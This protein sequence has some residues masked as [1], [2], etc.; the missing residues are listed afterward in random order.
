MLSLRSVLKSE[1]D[2]SID[3][4]CVMPVAISALGNDSSQV[5][6]WERYDLLED[7]FGISSKVY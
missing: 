2:L 7:S 6:T 5:I 3:R 4:E 1:F